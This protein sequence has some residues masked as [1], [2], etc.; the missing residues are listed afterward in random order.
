MP[1]DCLKIF[2]HSIRSIFAALWRS[3]ESYLG[4]LLTSSPR[5]VSSW[6]SVD[7][8]RTVTFRGVCIIN[9]LLA[10]EMNDDEKDEDWERRSCWA[11]WSRGCCQ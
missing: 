10:V 2:W 4:L 1:T 9:G 8:C 7:Y 5:V 11:I 3:E 6:D